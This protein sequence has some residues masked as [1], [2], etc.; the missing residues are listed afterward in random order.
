MAFQVRMRVTVI[1][2]VRCEG[3]TAEGAARDPFSYACDEQEV[4][5]VDWDVESV[6]EVD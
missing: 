1:K 2:L 4:D 6:T 5:Q 3:C